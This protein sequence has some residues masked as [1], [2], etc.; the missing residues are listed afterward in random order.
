MKSVLLV[1]VGFATAV[2]GGWLAAPRVMYK[3][4]P[5]PFAFNH[6]AHTGEK[7][8]MACADCH[9][10]RENASFAGIPR[11]ESCAACHGEPVGETKA[12]KDFVE[13]YVKSGREP[14]WKVY[15]RQPDN[16]WFPHAAHVN[17]AKL[18]CEQCHGDHGKSERPPVYRVNRITGYSDRLMTSM[19]MDHCV[20]CHKQRGLEHSCL[21]C[22]K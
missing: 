6:K 2:A 10:F 15:S 21:D 20:A 17:T 3:T 1:A 19:R 18:K 4:E 22:H 5:Q 8:G 14:E 11:L 9:G 16:A 7:G 12:E 13:R